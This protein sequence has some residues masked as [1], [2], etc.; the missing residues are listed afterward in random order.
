MQISFS[1]RHMAPVLVHYAAQYPKVRVELLLSDQR[2]N[3]VDEGLDLAIR[4]GPAQEGYEAGIALGTDRLVVCGAPAYFARHG[5]PTQPSDLV[6]QNC[7]LYSQAADGSEWHFKRGGKGESVRVDGSL[8]ADNGH[9]LAELAIQGAGLVRLSTFIVGRAIRAGQLQAILGDYDEEVIWIS[10]LP[11]SH[12]FIAN[13]V[14]LFIDALQQ[15]KR[16]WLEN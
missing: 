16:E 6:H 9:L 13:K 7:L 15:T 14:R 11:A 3:L 10:A 2:V 1:V 4:I 5:I 12:K 8:N